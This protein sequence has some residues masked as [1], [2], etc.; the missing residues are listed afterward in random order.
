M[1]IQILDVE[2]LDKQSPFHLQKKNILIE[3]GY[4]RSIDHNQYP[5]EKII[6]AQ[7]MKISTGWFDMRANFCDPGFEWKEDLV[8][9]L[10]A[11][12]AGGFTGIALLPNTDPIIQYKT[13]VFYLK[14]NPYQKTTKIY[15]IAALTKNLQGKQLTE[16]IDLHKIGAIAF[17]DGTKSVENGRTVL[18]A[19]QYLQ[20]FN[21]LFIQKAQ[22][23]QMAYG[24]MMHEG[25]H[26]M[27]LGIK[28]ISPIAEMLRVQRDLAILEHVGGRLHF[29]CISTAKAL[30]MIQQAK[31]KGL[32][33]SCDIAVYQPLFTDKDI[34]NFDTLYKVDPP[35]NTALNNEK[36]IKGLQKD[37]IDV[38]V[39]NHE[40]Q[41][42]N[43]KKDTFYQ[44][45]FGMIG[46]QTYLHFLIAL[47]QHLSWEKMIEKITREP[48]K[49]LQL[50]L[51]T[52][53]VGEKAN[54][55]LFDIYSTWKFNAKNNY[56]KSENTPLYGKKVNGK[57]IAVI[58]G[59]HM[60]FDEEIM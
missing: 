7:G 59:H 13:A 30:E 21:G 23:E 25:I 15:P 54:L 39:S 18:H 24:G 55:T 19:L 11:A 9:G 33:V 42:N 49:I 6:H 22:D 1:K 53:N 4:I 14:N 41:D 46:L 10:Q 12:T 32:K 17:S 44:S 56:S 58:H 50:P 43:S 38:M 37:V 52:I 29:S 36:L 16:L 35:L 47:S 60:Y 34:G 8:S 57:I 45:N 40:P 51:P 27:Q 31:E 48:R 5:A 20:Q 28:G 2:I 3:E 26:S